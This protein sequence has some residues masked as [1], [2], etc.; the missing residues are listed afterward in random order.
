MK[1]LDLGGPGLAAL[2]ALATSCARAPDD[3]APAADYP[4]GTVYVIDGVPVLASEVD[5]WIETIR[6]VQPDHTLPSLRRRALTNI[7]LQRAVGASID[8]NGRAVAE[9]MC[10][11]DL[12]LLQ[13]GGEL[14]LEGPQVQRFHE[15]WNSDVDIG[16]DRWGK[17]REVGAGTWTMF[18][19]IG[20]YTAMRLVSEP[21]SWR[22]DTPVAI[23]H[24]T[25]Y[26]LPTEGM[27]DI[28]EAAMDEAVIEIVDPTWERYLPT[29][30][31]HRKPLL[32]ED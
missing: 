1:L 27:H 25:H 10:R 26:Y 19:T 30:Y 31:L 24:V 32:L 11:R 20:G 5:E 7:V 12:E 29:H 23:E 2:L 3:E 28:L 18:E 4:E 9:E 17:G 22:M 8:P 13:Q 14:P 15:N 6:M 16:L 21:P